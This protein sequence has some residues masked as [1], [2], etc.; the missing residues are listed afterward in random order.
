MAAS[1]SSSAAI[2]NKK[3]LN[4]GDSGEESDEMEEDFDVNLDVNKLTAEHKATLNKCATQYGMQFG[5][6]IRMLIMDNEEKEQVKQNKLMEAEKAMHSGR[7]SRRQRRI[8]KERRLKERGEL[9]P[10]RWVLGS[11]P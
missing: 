1:A 8:A 6:Y 10:L 3:F 2:G 11:R 4:A 9:S 7:K 5:D